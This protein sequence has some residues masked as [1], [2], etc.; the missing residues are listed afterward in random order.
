M[1]N[2]NVSLWA[3]FFIDFNG[4]TRACLVFYDVSE[5]LKVSIKIIRFFY[6]NFKLCNCC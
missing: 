3:S 5:T 4:S 6:K 2:N 1:L